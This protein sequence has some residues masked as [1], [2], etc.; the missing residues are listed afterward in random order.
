MSGVYFFCIMPVSV[1]IKIPSLIKSFDKKLD[2]IIQED[3]PIL[4]K[5]K[6]HVVSSGGKR[7]RPLTHYFMSELHGYKGKLWKD[8]GAIAELIHGASLLH[9][10]VV[11]EADLRRGVPTVG[12]LHGNKTAILAGDYLLACGIEHLNGLHIPAIMDS[13][14]RVIRDLSV[15]EL[16]QME[17]EKNPK[18]TLKIYNDVIYGKTASLFGAVT[19][20][21]GILAEIGKRA[22]DELKKFGVTMGML[23]QMKDD[24][25]D[26]FQQT[27]KSGK[28]T[29][30][31][32]SNGLYTYPVIL[33]LEKSSKA[34]KSEINYL[35]SKIEKD[36]DDKKKILQFME[37]KGIPADI[38]NSLK[39]DAQ[40]LINY[41]SKFPDNSIKK[42]MIERIQG[43]VESE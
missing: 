10:D 8:V 18:I 35:I 41:L 27:S 15:G 29:L 36:D 13:F 31:D 42:L 38:T 25:I 3:L 28:I 12:A 4:K 23:F 1:T 17:W 40:S 11:D 6:T 33:L 24:Y 43:I 7:I 14:T 34:E 19:E 32:F 21:A 16:I 39:K 5:I 26:Y 2:E 22:T 9:D 30:K 37:A 20:T